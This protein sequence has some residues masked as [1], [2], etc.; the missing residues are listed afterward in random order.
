MNTCSHYCSS[1]LPEWSYLIEWLP[2]L[3]IIAILAII[4]IFAIKYGVEYNK[5]NKEYLFKAQSEEKQQHKE[6]SKSFSELNN[7]IQELTKKLDSIG[8]IES[9]L[10]EDVNNLETLLDTPKEENINY[11]WNCSSSKDSTI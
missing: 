9:K 1:T 7:A 4:A 10:R 11:S 8:P 6:E 2:W 5:T 3:I